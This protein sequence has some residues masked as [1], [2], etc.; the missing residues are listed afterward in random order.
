MRWGKRLGL[1]TVVLLFGTVAAAE[2]AGPN[3]YVP[4]A[5]GET[6]P[7]D[8]VVVEPGDHLWKISQ[9]EMDRQLGRTA[10]PEEVTPY[11]GSMI[12]LNRASLL[13]GDPDLIY[14]GE[15]IA[16]PRPGQGG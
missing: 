13:S 3:P 8:S 6:T 12:E 11:W 14:P 5:I 10:A 2:P 7:P 15:V 16:L 1:S 9:T 4:V